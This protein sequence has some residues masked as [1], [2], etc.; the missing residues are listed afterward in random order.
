MPTRRQTCEGGQIPG[1]FA[2]ANSCRRTST[3]TRVASV[4]SGGKMSRQACVKTHVCWTLVHCFPLSLF[5]GGEG[6]RRGSFHFSRLS[7]RSRTKQWEA[8]FSSIAGIIIRLLLLCSFLSDLMGID[9]VR[10]AEN[11]RSSCPQI[12]FTLFT[13]N[14]IYCSFNDAGQQ[15]GLAGCQGHPKTSGLHLF[16]FDI[17]F[18]GA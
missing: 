1:M 18:K 12:S 6:P 13:Q 16:S 4:T 9:I 7:S 14:C 5:N 2:G 10:V 11:A 3:G 8:A 17:T 15:N